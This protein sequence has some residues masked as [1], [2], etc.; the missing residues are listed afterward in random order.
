MSYSRWTNS[1]FYTFMTS[2]LRF[3]I[4]GVGTYTREDCSPE[5]WA[6]TLEKISAAEGLPLTPEEG[7]ELSEYKDEF[8]RDYQT[9]KMETHSFD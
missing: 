7:Q 6:E 4:C 5:R 9:E 3:E 1:R 8:L 2:D